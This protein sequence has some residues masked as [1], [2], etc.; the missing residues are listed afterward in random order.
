MCNTD[1]SCCNFWDHRMLSLGCNGIWSLCSHLLCPP[2]FINMSPKV[3]VT[4]ITASYVGGLL[5]ASVHTVATFSLSFCAS[6]ESKHVFCD[7]PSLLAVSCSDTHTNQLLFFYFVDYIVLVTILIVLISYGFILLAILRMHYA[8]GKRKVFSTCGSH[9]TGV[10]IFHGTI[11]FMYV[12]PSS[13]YAL[14]HYMIVSIFYS[15]VIP[16][17]NLII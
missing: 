15:I 6:N 10:P 1:V 14:D 5:P 12:R 11:F 2:V 7:I 13:S 16:M 9:W 17:L 8:E 4:L 3:F